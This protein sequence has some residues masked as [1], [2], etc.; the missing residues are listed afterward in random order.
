MLEE[1]PGNN[2]ASLNGIA[3][4]QD[5]RSFPVLSAVQAGRM[6]DVADPYEVG[7]GVEEITVHD[8]RDIG[9]RAFALTVEGDSMISKPPKLG[10]KS[11]NEGDTIICDPDA[12]LYPGC[13]VIAKTADHQKATFKKYRPLGEDENGV[14]IID[15]VPLNED[16]PTIRIDA[17]H[18]GIV[19]GRV[20]RRTERV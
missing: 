2:A 10:E 9:P 17:N 5:V 18:P 20:V 7:G 4:S 13:Y 16:W 12:A 8:A 14:E 19:I 6:V 11:F 1:V 15:L 3:S